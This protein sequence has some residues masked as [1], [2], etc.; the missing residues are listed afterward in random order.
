MRGRAQDGSVQADDDG[1][2]LGWAFDLA[3]GAGREQPRSSRLLVRLVRNQAAAPA[4]ASAA[5]R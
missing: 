5:A 2:L 1:L 4:A 3:S